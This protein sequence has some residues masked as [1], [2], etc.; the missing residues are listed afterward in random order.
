MHHLVADDRIEGGIR[1]GELLDY[2]LSLQARISFS[3]AGPSKAG[4]NPVACGMRPRGWARS[5]AHLGA[6][7]ILPRS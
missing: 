6:L 5:S 4:H 1:E 7:L 2:P 3:S